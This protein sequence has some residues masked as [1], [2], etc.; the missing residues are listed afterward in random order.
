MGRCQHCGDPE[1]GIQ[2]KGHI[3][4]VS[5]GRVKRGSSNVTLDVNKYRYKNWT[6]RINEEMS[7]ERSFYG[8]TADCL[9]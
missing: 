1:K 2:T 8:E 6:E 9:V 5:C 4:C 3:F 7:G